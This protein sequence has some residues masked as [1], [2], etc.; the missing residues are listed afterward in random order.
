MCLILVFTSVFGGNVRIIRAEEI[1][2]HSIALTI[3]GNGRVNYTFFKSDD[4]S[5]DAGEVDYLEESGTIEIPSDAAKVLIKAEPGNEYHNG[6]VTGKGL[7]EGVYGKNGKRVDVSPGNSYEVSITFEQDN[8]PR[9]ENGDIRFDIH[10]GQ[11]G[12]VY[13]AVGSDSEGNWNEVVNPL[14]SKSD[15]NADGQTIYIKAV[16]NEGHSLDQGNV[17]NSICVNGNNTGITSELNDN[18]GI[19]SF[20][21]SENDQYEIRIEFSGSGNP[22]PGPEGGNTAAGDIEI[23]V[24]NRN[25]QSKVEYKIGEGDDWVNIEGTRLVLH[26]TDELNSVVDGTNIYFKATPNN[27]QILDTHDKQNCIRI[28]GQENQIEVEKLTEGDFYIEYN[29]TKADEVQIKFDGSGD[30]GQN[31]GPGPQGGDSSLAWSTLDGTN[32]R[33]DDMFYK[34]PGDDEWRVVR[35]NNPVTLQEGD[36]LLIRVDMNYAKY[37]IVNPKFEYH[38]KTNDWNRCSYIYS[39]G[40]TEPDNELKYQLGDENGYAIT[41]KPENDSKNADGEPSITAENATLYIYFDTKNH[42]ENEAELFIFAQLW[43]DEFGYGTYAERDIDG[44]RVEVF[45]DSAREFDGVETYFN[46]DLYNPYELHAARDNNGNGDGLNG[47]IPVQTITYP[48]GFNGKTGNTTVEPESFSY[49]PVGAKISGEEKNIIRIENRDNLFDTVFVISGENN[50]TFTSADELG[51]RTDERGRQFVEIE[52]DAATQYRILV[53]RHDDPRGDIMWNYQDRGDDTFVDHGKLFIEEV[54]RGEDVVYQIA[55]DEKGEIIFDENGIPVSAIDELGHDYTLT[56]SGGDFYLYKGD[57]I[58]IKLIPTYGYQIEKADL[59]GF[60]MT[61]D[62][63]EVSLF[64]FTLGGNVHL[65]GTFVKANDVISTSASE[66]SQATISSGENATDSGVL[67]LTVSDHKGNYSN[68]QAAL[69]K[70]KNNNTHKSAVA[71]ATLDMLLK[72]LVSKGN[73]DYWEKGITSFEDDISVELKLNDNYHEGDKYVVVREHTEGNETK[74]EEISVTF[75]SSTNILSIPTN[76]FSTYSIIR[77]TDNTEPSDDVKEDKNEENVST[78][79]VD[80]TVAQAEKEIK[81][82]AEDL[83]VDF[84]D[85]D[86]SEKFEKEVAT[87]LENTISDIKQE[88][89]QKVAVFEND[90]IIEKEPVVEVMDVSTIKTGAGYTNAMIKSA[91]HFEEAKCDVGIV[92][93]GDWTFMNKNIAKVWE[94]CET[95][96]VWV[97]KHKGRMIRVTIPKGTD[98]SSILDGNGFAGPLYIG[99]VLGTT[100][101]IEE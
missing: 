53:R 46:G 97:F 74:L 35:P 89:T 14:L 29:H 59:C 41:F 37:E 93:T 88:L 12:K 33:V 10:N 22:G 20:T 81:L 85:T 71:V 24:N 56:N 38:D 25:Y 75:N 65:A 70:A 100:E 45:I 23:I 51:W 79:Q 7:D 50:T 28:D 68:A 5:C 49:M 90:K 32:D 96:I 55:K 30:P 72:G 13:Y 99:K 9:T 92:Y 86:L 6:S 26:G 17:A 69:E 3:E 61:P 44:E 62:E 67:N 1:T 47:K 84:T 73:G 31:P 4:S 27:L 60:P 2:P 43:N 19:Y 87:A 78:S 11:K 63:N 91:E 8:P 101:I 54:K 34:L 82:D 21:Y 42:F 18:D 66:V 36:T 48:T 64:T 16:P 58:K 57:V 77:M 80:N 40:T 94:T 52:V 95:D 83:S 39:N 98:I 15:L 76:K